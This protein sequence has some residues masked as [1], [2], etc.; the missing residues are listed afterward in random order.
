MQFMAPREL[1]GADLSV[2]HPGVGDHGVR[3]ESAANET[4]S[5]CVA[6]ASPVNAIESPRLVIGP[7][8]SLSG[9]LARDAFTVFRMLPVRAP[10]LPGWHVRSIPPNERVPN[11]LDVL[12]PLDAPRGGLPLQLEPNRT[13]FFWVDVSVPRGTNDGVYRTYLEL[14]SG[15]GRI[16]QKTVELTVLP[17][18]LPDDPGLTILAELD[19]RLLFRQH[20][21]R[22]RNAFSTGLDEWRD[23]SRRAELTETLFAT[24]RLLESHGVTPVLHQL[25]PTAKMSARNGLTLD[26]TG[27]DAL[28]EPILTGR[29]F[30]DRRPPSVWPIPPLPQPERMVTSTDRRRRAE[31]SHRLTRDYLEGCARHFA[32]RG[33]LERNYWIPPTPSPTSADGLAMLRSFVTSARRAH[34]GLRV[35]SRGCPQDLRPYGMPD[36]VRFD[37]DDPIDIWMPPA[38]FYDPVLMGVERER[39]RL[40]WIDA[41]DPPYL[42][43]THVSAPPS[44][45]QAMGWIAAGLGADVI[46]LGCV[47][48]WPDDGGNPTPDM[49]VAQ[50]PHVLLYPGASFGLAHP[51]ASVRLKR[52]R[53]AAQDMGLRRLLLGTNLDHV[54]RTLESTLVGYAGSRAYRAHYADGRPIGWVNEPDHYDRA[55]RI[56]LEGA[57][58]LDRPST[59]R[60]SSEFESTTDWQRLM[61]E[62]RSVQLSVDGCNARYTG[63]ADSWRVETTCAV[64][65]TNRRRVPIQGR[66]RFAKVPFGWEDAGDG[67]RIDAIPPNGSRRAILTISSAGF[68][69][70]TGGFAELPVEMLIDGGRMVETTARVSFATAI[71]FDGH[72]TI[73]GDLSDWAPGSVNML[74]DFRLITGGPRDAMD[75]RDTHPRVRTIGFVRQDDDYL[76]V[77]VNTEFDEAES[78]R[79]HQRNAVT[80]D[81]LTPA[82]EPLVEVL[83]DPLNTG[84]RSPADLYHLVVKPSG[85]HLAERGIGLDPPVGART[86]WASDAEV[87]TMLHRGRWMTEIRVPWSAFDD[88]PR[89]NSVWGF[90]ITRYDAIGQQYSTWSGAEGNAY[91]PASLGN[92]FVPAIPQRN[93]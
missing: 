45:T 26:W 28:V 62:S 69:L 59:P 22:V 61:S 48:R 1:A 71:P 60:T 18:T 76:Y 39:G 15:E 66:L 50:D 29:I 10:T 72:G 25:A 40:S 5:F 81:G 13:Y 70:Q 2:H 24:M 58:S 87:G 90:N 84:T 93:Q 73:D 51:V 52:L 35:V 56:M 86:P 79:Q 6:I 14:M 64:G 49:C 67:K 12:V 77:A 31:S 89:V 65:I 68:P 47:N 16:A 17:L 44:Y 75:E 63:T 85:A 46:R 91:D 27:Y 36:A 8:D 38:R 30:E 34:P 41:D 4:V 32:M 20:D 37:P 9:R 78:T 43:S 92:V 57:M 54:A 23:A 88:A 3:L 33:W 80:Y 42:G 55:R 19:H 74:G 82:G 53:R 11:P 83:I 21:A 7:I